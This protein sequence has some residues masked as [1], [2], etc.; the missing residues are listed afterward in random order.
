VSTTRIDLAAVC[1]RST[2]LR[3]LDLLDRDPHATIERSFIEPNWR[4]P[5]PNGVPTAAAPIGDEDVQGSDAYRA[6]GGGG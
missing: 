2:A 6:G 5:F 1:S 4:A 3:I